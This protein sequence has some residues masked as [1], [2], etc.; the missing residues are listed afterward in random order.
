[1]DEFEQF[2]RNA[3]NDEIKLLFDEINGNSISSIKELLKE[4]SNINGSNFS[5]ASDES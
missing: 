5:D 2:I 4:K 3:T 1:M